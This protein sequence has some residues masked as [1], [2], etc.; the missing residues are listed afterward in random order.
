MDDCLQEF[1]KMELFNRK[2]AEEIRE[3]ETE[4]KEIEEIIRENKALQEYTGEYRIIKQSES[5]E[6]IK[7]RDGKNI[8]VFLTKIPTLDKYTGGFRKGQLIVISAPTG[9]GKT[10]FCQTLTEEFYLQGYKCLWFTFEV[11]LV[12]FAEKFK[13]IPEFYVPRRLKE[14]SLDWLQ[15]RMREGIA[16]YGTEIIFI[17]HLHFL[18]D[19]KMLARATNTSTLIGMIMRELKKFAIKYGVTIFLVTHLKKTRIEDD[20]NIDD[21]R[22][23][24]FIAQ[25]SDVVMIMWRD[26]QKDASEAGGWRYTNMARLLITKNRR[27]GRLGGVS[28]TYN[29][30]KFS[31]EAREE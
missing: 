30:N 7:K 8:E 12:E 27:T 9:Q 3:N 5:L 4:L 17:D 13:E 29:N 10:S 16:K 28:L 22:D 23:S 24:S 21:L 6:E 26:K 11:P 18:L 31:E 20:P 2:L 1:I 15:L 25:E 14:A 19:F